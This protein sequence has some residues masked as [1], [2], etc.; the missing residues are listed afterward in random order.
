MIEYSDFE[1]IVLDKLGRDI[2]VDVNEDQHDAI[3]ASP[4]TSLFVVAGPGSGKTTVMVLKILKFILVDDIKPSSILA[5]TFTR[6]AASQLKSRTVEW[7]NELKS[8][9]M[10]NPK[11]SS[12]KVL[13]KKLDFR[14]IVT[15]TLDSIAEDILKSSDRGSSPA[16]IEDLVSNALMIKVG[17]MDHDRQKNKDLQGF[18]NQIRGARTRLNVSMMSQ[19]LLEIKDRIFHDRIDFEKF[20]ED[21]EHPGAEPAY[22]AI[23]D[24]IND[25]KNRNL[26]D[27][28]ML[29]DEFLRKL[30]TDKLKSL[31]NIKIVL[32]DEYQD[33]NLLQETIYLKIAETAVKN[34]GSIIVVGDDDQSLYR[35]RGATVDL[36][37]DFGNRLNSQLGITSLFVNLSKNYRSTEHIVDFCNEFIQIDKEFQNARAAGKRSISPRLENPNNVPVLG[38]FRED[39]NTLAADLAEFIREI[40]HGE[41]ITLNYK[42]NSFKIKINEREG[43][44]SDIAFLC[45][46]P[47]E[48]DFKGNSRLPILLKDELNKINPQIPVFNPRGQ[49]LGR[50]PVIETLCGMLLECIDPE[51]EIQDSSGRL[52]RNAVSRFKIWRSKALTYIDNKEDECKEIHAFLDTW[53]SYFQINEQNKVEVP[54]VDLIYKMVKWIPEI[55][56]EEG[57]VYLEIIIKTITQT[58]LF[59]DFKS[60]IILNGRNRDTDQNSVTE[61]LWNI[62][63]PIALGAIN[64]DLDILENLP[65]NGINIMSIHQSKGLEFPIVIVDVGSDFKMNYANHAFKRFPGTPG[66]SCTLEDN[67]R[68][69]SKL[70]KPRRIALDRAFDDIIR[71]YF[72]AFSRPQGLLLLVGLN[73]L[74]DG[75]FFNNAVRYV[76]NIATGWDRN[77]EWHWKGLDNL[78]HI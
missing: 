5:T 50:I 45:S 25:L 64:L 21:Y 56:D 58:S 55:L 59:S 26:L 77:G 30:Q 46:S 1:K 65:K 52:P 24:Y 78:F 42:N 12:I 51:G 29:E 76:P 13:L 54:L 37:T 61:V 62:F 31:K 44:P 17:L 38:M 22:D 14:R 19:I 40:S 57:L 48:L 69:F 9:L 67:M 7:G 71:Q 35:F 39:I 4:D 53:R 66:K 74:K 41:G 34:N 75:Y 49:S 43:F 68:K 28:S 63:V 60:N 32:V 3:T 33:T 72:V 11:Y 73:S 15:G 2:R 16:I 20:I 8:T 6:K 36:F 47:L 23:S 27:F 18:L 10:E 70:G